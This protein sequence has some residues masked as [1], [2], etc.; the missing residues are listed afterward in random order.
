MVNNAK[1]IAKSNEEKGCVL[2]KSFFL[3]K[4]YP[5][6]P[7]ADID[8]PH[9]YSKTGHITNKVILRQ[10]CMLKLY[11]V[12]GPNSISNIVLTKCADILIDR[13]YYIYL[14]IYNN[15]LYYSL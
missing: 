14:A 7:M 2:A 9:Q 8:Y 6:P 10:L 11:K 3:P 13:L 12:P 15:K 5:E 4:P 1:C